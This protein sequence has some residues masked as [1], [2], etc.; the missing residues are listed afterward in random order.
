MPRHPFVEISKRKSQR[1]AQQGQS[2]RK[3]LKTLSDRH[4][5]GA[6]LSLTKLQTN[7]PIE[8]ERSIG[9]NQQSANSSQLITFQPK[10]YKTDIG[11]IY[12]HV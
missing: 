11:E 12:F 5:C 4:N 9:S 7:P 1:R 10:V 8:R 6:P 2:L 3:K